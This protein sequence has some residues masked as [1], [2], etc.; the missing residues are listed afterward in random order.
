MFNIEKFKK[1]EI[2]ESYQI[3]VTIRSY[4]DL[5]AFLEMMF[6]K[7]YVWATNNDFIACK[8]ALIEAFPDYDYFEYI[9]KFKDREISEWYRKNTS[10]Q[11]AFDRIMQSLKRMVRKEKIAK[12]K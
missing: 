9:M 12:N 2:D 7:D 8:I 4:S 11:E 6:S 1:G 10:S 5:S 3:L